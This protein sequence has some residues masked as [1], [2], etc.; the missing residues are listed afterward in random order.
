MTEAQT[1]S[2]VY[3]ATATLIDGLAWSDG[4][5]DSVTVAM[6]LTEEGSLSGTAQVTGSS[7]SYYGAAAT[8]WVDGELLL[9]FTK[10]GVY[11]LP[12]TTEARIL[13]VGGGGGGG[14]RWSN[15][16]K[17]A[18]GGGGA[19]GLVETSGRYSGATYVVTVGA[20][21]A[22]GASSGTASSVFSGSPGG[23]TT[24]ATADGEAV[25]T[26]V[27]GGGGG[28][29]NKSGGSGGSGGG[30]GTG[31]ESGGTGTEGQGFAGGAAA[32]LFGGGGGG[33]G[34]VGAD[35]ADGNPTG[36]A[37]LSSDITGE[38]VT[39]AGGGGGGHNVEGAEAVAG[40][41][42]GGG[43]GGG[44]AAAVAGEDGLGGGGGGAGTT[45]RGG[46]G[47]AG[48]VYVR[49]SATMDGEFV[50]PSDLI[51]TYDGVAHTS[52]VA[53]AYY[54]VT[55]DA[56]GT[57]VGTYEA[58]AT[59]HDGVTW[60]DG[61]TESVTVT[62]TILQA[63][64][65]LAD[66]ALAGWSYG[67]RDAELPQPTCTVT[68]A[69][70]A[71]V[72][73]YAAAADSETWSTTRPT[74][75]GTYWVR[76]RVSDA[77]NYSAN[78][79]DPVSFTIS[80][81]T[82]TFADL[83]LRDWM[84]GTPAASTPDPTCTV[85][86]SWVVPKYEYAAS[87]DATDWSTEKPTA[88]GTWVVRASAPDETNYN[89]EPAYAEFH[90]VK[91]L[92]NLYAD[93][94]EISLLYTAT[95]SDPAEL[96]DF[97]YRVTLSETSPVG[98]LY[99]RAGETGGEMAF[100]D[101]SGDNILPYWVKTWDT[102]DVS[103]VYVKIPTI[104]S[105]VEQKIR[106][107]WS[108]RPAAD[109]PA[110]DPGDDWI[111]SAEEEYGK[112]TNPPDER[113]E[114]PVSRDGYL[115]NYWT[116]LPAMSKTWWQS[117]DSEP[118]AIAQEAVLKFGTVRRVITNVVAAVGYETLPTTKIGAYR[119]IWSQADSF[120][121]EPLSCHIDFVI[122]GHDYYDGL[123]EGAGL[124]RSGRVFLANDDTAAGHAVDGQGYWRTREVERP[125]GSILTNDIYWTHSGEHATVSLMPNL[126]PG[127]SHRLVSVEADGS[128]NVLWRFEDVLFGNQYRG[129]GY[130]ETYMTALPWSATS[131]AGTSYETREDPATAVTSTSVILRNRKGACVY[132]PCYTNGIGTIYFDAVNGFSTNLERTHYRIV[133][134][135]ATSTCEGLEPTDEN[136]AK[137]DASG[138]EGELGLIEDAQWISGDMIPLKRNGTAAF[139][140]EAATNDLSLA[141]TVGQ[142][143]NGYYRVCV[144]VNVRGPAR[145]R[146]RRI[147][148]DETESVDGRSMILLDNIVVSPAPNTAEVE[149]YGC[150][151]ATKRGKQYL[152][153]MGA[154]S[155]PF[156][157]V[158]DKAVYARAK[159]VVYSNGLTD[160]DPASFV[161]MAKMHYRWTYLGQASNDWQTVDLSPSD[162][163]VS[164]TPMDIP[165]MEGD[166]SWW[167]EAVVQMPTYRYYDYSGLGLGLAGADGAALYTEEVTSVTNR[168]A[169]WFARLRTGK[170]DWEGFRVVVKESETG[171]ETVGEMDLVGDRLWRGRY[172]TPAAVTDG[173]YVRFEAVNRQ[174][175]GATD[176][177]TN[178]TAYVIRNDADSLPADRT[179]EAAA[180]TSTWSRVVCDAKTGYLLF[181]VDESTRGV[182]VVHADYQNFNKWDDAN[183]TDRLFVGTSTDTNSTGIAGVA[184]TVREFEGDF[185]RWDPSSATNALYWTENFQNGVSAAAMGPGGDWEINLP[186][187]ESRKSPNG[188]T[189]GPG[190]WVAGAY[191]DTTTGMALQMEGRGVG[192]IQFVNAAV[193][194]RGLESVRFNARLGQAIE[195]DDFSY[196]DGG[197]KATM[198]N[199]TFVTRA[200]YDIN[201]RR[202]FVGN[203]SLS[204]VAFYRPGIGAYEFRVEQ[205]NAVKGSGGNVTGA[206][207]SH[208]LSLLRWRYDETSGEVVSTELGSV[209]VDGGASMLTTASANGS[210]GL[211][212]ISVENT[213]AATRISAGV[214]T[215]VA[216]AATES[217]GSSKTV[218][219]VDSGDE[220]LTAGTYGVLAANCPGRFVHPVYGRVATAMPTTATAFTLTTGSFGY[221]TSRDNCRL[222]LLS[223]LWV[224]RPRRAETANLTD[225]SSY[226]LV[227]KEVT[228]ALNIYTA[229]SGTT[230]WSLLATTNVTSFCYLDEPIEV[231]LWSLADCAVKIAPGGNAKSAR[232]DVVIDDLELR[233]WRGES[234]DESDVFDNVYS[235]SPSNVV[236]TQGWILTNLVTGAKSCELNARRSLPSVATSIRSPL[237]DG[238]DGRGSGL[239]MFTFTYTNAQ[240]NASL[241]LQICTNGVDATTLAS[242]SKDTSSAVWTTVT[243]Y[244]F[245]T[246]TDAER[247]SGRRSYY[248]GLHGVTGVMRLC[249]DPSLVRAVTNATDEAAFG[250]IA[251]TG[252][253]CR[254]EPALDK[255]AWWGW[256]LRTTDEADKLWLF[257]SGADPNRDGMALALN[258]SVADDVRAEE[259]ELYPEHL[260]FVQTP[261]FEAETVGEVSFRA[262][263]Y[264][265]SGDDDAVPRVTLFGAKLGAAAEDA[266]WTRLASWD[267]TNALYRTFTHKTASGDG[268]C[269]F[270]LAVSGVP[271]VLN[272]MPD[273]YAPKKPLRVLIDEVTVMEALRAR[274]AFRN[275]A[276]F[277]SGLDEATAVAVTDAFGALLSDEQ[278][279]CKEA[280]GVQAEVY[281]AQ[282]ADELDLSDA[283]VRLWWHEG[284]SPWGFENWK[285]TAEAN[286]DRAWL[287]ACRGTN[288]VFRSS[289]F[290]A[291]D[292]VMEAQ[293]AAVTVQYMLEVVYRTG[294]G[295]VQT[296][297]LSSADWE[298]PSWYNPV[299]LNAQLA[300]DGA[301]SG[302]TILDTVSP[303]WAWINEANIFGEYTSSWMNS[304][305]DYQFL[306]VA[307]PSDADLSEWSIRLVDAKISTGAIVT[308]EI[309][310]FG[311]ELPGLKK[312]VLNMDPV[313]KS[314]FHVVASP[315]AVLSFDSSKGELDGIWRKPAQSTASASSGGELD[316]TYPIALQLVRPTGIIEH[317]IV[318]LGTNDWATAER[319]PENHVTF[320]NAQEKAVGG[321]GKFF[322]VGMDNG[323][324]GKSLGVFSSRGETPLVW[325]AT[326]SWTPGRINE[327]QVIPDGCPHPLGSGL[328][329][330]AFLSGD[331]IW[332]S[333]DGGA[334]YTN[335][336]KTVV[337]RKGAEEGT[338]ILYRTDRWYELGA[339]T[340]NGVVAA[341]T[342]S[343][344]RTWTLEVAKNASND[345]TVSAA[346]QVSSALVENYGLGADNVYRDAVLAWLA[347]GKTLKGD[348][349]NPDAE[350]PG[351]ADFAEISGKFTTNLTL[352]TMY[353]LDMDPTWDD[354]DLCLRGGMLPPETNRVYES[355]G[356]TYTTVV[357][358]AFMMITNTVTDTAWPPY[359]IR[360][361]A[362]GVT[363]WGYGSADWNWSNV[364]FKVTGLLLNAAHGEHGEFAG[365]NNRIPLGYYLF[366]E[367][368]FETTGANAF[369]TRIELDDPYAPWSLG[370][371]AG[372][373]DWAKE[374]GRETI[375]YS[376]DIDDR[377]KPTTVE[378]LKT[379]NWQNLPTD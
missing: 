28:G 239:G 341:P 195:F 229:P 272:L 57:D 79:L 249:V 61:T 226:A 257:D 275:V 164:Q 59:L 17:S 324:S 161:S 368:S 74:A 123:G 12:G 228:Q 104:V 200:A 360:S 349:H 53:N 132:S 144:P 373:Y 58:T 63:S 250:S 129:A 304:D 374:H 108:L 99:A 379:E 292:A 245:D 137:P 305:K 149:P 101:E 148:A 183:R 185:D 339:V 344:T 167:Y 240:K 303:G 220:R 243:N 300:S 212:F 355:G 94:V 223:D 78:D 32:A 301:F 96:T 163:F 351:L 359:V 135:V 48:G 197:A 219:F 150:F 217:G 65:T 10:F 156:P 152:G 22:G 62:L 276:A 92:G 55:G 122:T 103:T 298:K 358:R 27:G 210:Y 285:A 71:V 231:K 273:A 365:R 35:A 348:F 112:V 334:T 186:F 237:M 118:G 277:R 254:D 346:A 89:Y 376:F 107:Y 267:V 165:A 166:V 119:V 232:N 175:A 143:T 176:Y 338:N 172:Q 24:V 64:V 377:L 218:S 180:G 206:G 281:A 251:I 333:F 25:V 133:V 328:M 29:R 54:D 204:L 36:G 60:P 159:P 72:Y 50:K 321:E 20:G 128:T 366:D 361:A 290:G 47:G 311:V 42:G 127:T 90:I 236:Y 322:Y 234:Y 154:L 260:P 3:T 81:R 291:S 369:T 49:I 117:D 286:G 70:V 309:A 23:D 146:I 18:G 353:W 207:N 111:A 288:L 325:N 11:R 261:T 238:R 222:D 93:Y 179:L 274:V 80:V 187:T 356:A 115:V 315:N 82:V 265:L 196:Y 38:S 312:D 1:E 68:P 319:D 190:Q 16:A 51:V 4:T 91:G 126:L 52:L 181:Q 43:A 327:S 67:A 343:G 110:H 378:V 34:G 106:L 363:S 336:T 279:L 255:F 5:T 208:R 201:Q 98:F 100:T 66:L 345:V 263:R 142:S 248:F 121:Y 114:S 136:A 259:E 184:S 189:V 266:Q 318:A 283:R 134:E 280:W 37:G 160:T 213:G 46:A 323:G 371:A 330:Y 138:I 233:Q 194:P 230:D 364:T 8:N 13:A 287:M 140:A 9:K 97:P 40:G 83:L 247:L 224:V 246:C 337:Y 242:V 192:Y 191:R 88:V 320:L 15:G 105:G 375:G 216:T 306:E 252:V 155:V 289:Y 227:A 85:T 7:V 269:A 116:T 372:W 347:G 198:T 95:G 205:E 211:L 268:Y 168:N 244:T 169:N 326:M 235:G 258:N 145:F 41:A 39:Y 162:G 299:D 113:F 256:N 340:T 270:R 295:E 2:G 75:V 188:L 199:Y 77:K 294:A 225:P 124:T 215:G 350:T 26:A 45:G 30:A 308:N 264:D 109:A 221:P 174:A 241:L 19:G 139:V 157:S 331:H 182:S 307:A 370:G 203:G 147:E 171:V 158:S 214:S 317:E 151:D 354:H 314:V 170:S 332:Q 84:Q 352:T 178:L 76:V 310:R 173:L 14:G 141:I 56:I 297:W 6:I 120:G 296:N 73:E 357:M 271:N 44:A 131:L 21:G 177:A 282:L 262:R 278:P 209:T 342:A 125:D 87:E 362:P 293:N 284:L 335:A 86:P 302:Y 313:S 367:N 102:N 33:A 253:L 130:L 329:I 316:M 193:S 202:D 31:D 153:Q 69:G